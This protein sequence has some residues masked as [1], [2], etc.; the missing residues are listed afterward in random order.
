MRIR[1]A[2]LHSSS[3]SNSSAS[4]NLTELTYPTDITLL[5]ILNKEGVANRETATQ[6]V[7]HS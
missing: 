1:A 6:H 4:C 7:P 5:S 2:S 3:D